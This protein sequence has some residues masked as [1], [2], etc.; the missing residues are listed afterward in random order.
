V[1]VSL[2]ATCVVDLL[3]PGVGE[4]SARLLRAVGCEVRLNRAQ[5]CCGQPGWNAGH[6][7]EAAAVARPTLEALGSDL[8]DGADAVVVPAGSCASMVRVF[9]PELFEVV[10]DHEAAAL[11]RRVAG[12]TVELSEL[13]ARR[14]DRLPPLALGREVVA[15]E[16]RACHALRELRLDGQ[17]AELLARVAGC[18][19][20]PMEPDDADR[21]CGFGGTFSVKLPETSVAMADAKL[22]AAVATGA[23]VVVSTDTSCLAHLRSRATARGLPVTTRHLAE[24]LAAALPPEADTR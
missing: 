13:L 10:G 1:R 9:W 3:E 2:L 16:H 17:P 22:D 14:A 21:C 23:E 4:A 24:V 20:A 11:A 19:L 15:T 8:D 12:A 18:S 5:T 7:E 6:A